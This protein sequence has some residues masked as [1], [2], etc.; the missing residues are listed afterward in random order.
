MGAPRVFLESNTMQQNGDASYQS[1]LYVNVLYSSVTSGSSTYNYL[2]MKPT[3][4][5]IDLDSMIYTDT[6]IGSNLKLSTGLFRVRRV[7]AELS[8]TSNYAS[9][10]YLVETEYTGT[11]A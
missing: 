8:F 9:G 10:N 5:L 3:A 6:E 2:L 11:R 1:I 7:A 4:S